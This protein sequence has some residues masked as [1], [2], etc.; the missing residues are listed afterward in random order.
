MPRSGTSAVSV[1]RDL[2]VFSVCLQSGVQ[3][4]VWLRLLHESSPDHGR[5]RAWASQQVTTPLNFHAHQEAVGAWWSVLVSDQLESSRWGEGRGKPNYAEYGAQRSHGS[6]CRAAGTTLVATAGSLYTRTYSTQ[7]LLGCR[8]HCRWRGPW[9]G[10]RQRGGSA[11]GAASHRR[12]PSGPV[13]QIMTFP[14]ETDITSSI[15]A[16]SCPLSPALFEA[17]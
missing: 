5:V 4:E 2:R 10:D 14:D 1:E 6:Q 16:S 9:C 12:R 11:A 8:R 13:R 7:L 15:I 17:P 3:P